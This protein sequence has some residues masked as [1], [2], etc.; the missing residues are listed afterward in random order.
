MSARQE[1]LSNASIGNGDGGTGADPAGEGAWPARVKYAAIAVTI[2]ALIATVQALP[3]NQGLQL[4]VQWVEGLGPAAP[5]AF[6]VI[7]FIATMLMLPAWPLSVASGMI[8]GLLW[9]TVFVAVGATSGAAGAFIL[10]RYAAR[11]LVEDKIRHYPRFAAV[12]R[13]VGEGGWKIVALLR[14]SPALPFTLQNYVYGLTAIRFW[15]CILATAA[16]ILPGT[17][18]YVYFGYAGRASLAAAEGG[19]DGGWAQYALMG[20]GLV[21]TVAVTVY[22]TKIARRAIHQH[23]IID[24]APESGAVAE[25]E[26]ARPWRGAVIAVVMAVFAATLAACAQIQPEFLMRFFRPPAVVM[27]EAYEDKADGAVYDHSAFDAILKAHVNEAGGVDYRAIQ[28]NPEALLAYNA[29]LA[30]AP[31]DDLGRNE[32]LALLI[33]AYN[34]FTLELIIEWLDDDF[35]SI[36]EIPR[37]KSWNDERWNVGG[38]AWSLN[39]IEHEEI[40]PKFVEPDIHWVLVCAAVGCPPLRREVY[41]GAKLEAQLRDQ[42]RIVHTDGSRWF[43][44][45]PDQNTLGLTQLYNW[46]GSDFEQ[47]AGTVVD[48]AAKYAPTLEE[49]L[50]DG[51]TS[52]VRWLDYD[53]ALNNQE[54][55]S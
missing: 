2:V 52:K 37:A 43:Q 9:G 32:R 41:T 25:K 14:L 27:T 11:G 35:T 10:T 20:A 53:W 13:A 42:A 55:L 19:V 40:R 34:S 21:A 31:Y 26:V 51:R 8:F 50:A 48:Y 29:A 22:I 18:M 12:D 44:Y 54:N 1:Y 7:Y 45:D 4:A 28:E 30:E 5:L 23:T 36:R 24:E 47:V 46:Y 6:I 15:P 38:H 33:N 3:V 49:A 17:F 16:A 39:Q